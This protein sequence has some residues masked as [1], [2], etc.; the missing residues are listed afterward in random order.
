[1]IDLDD[2]E[3]SVF[4]CDCFMFMSYI[5]DQSIDL[6]LTD[7]PFNMTGLEYDCPINLEQMWK[8]FNRIIKPNGCMCIN[9]SQPFTT[10]LNYPNLKYFRYEWIWKKH[11]PSNFPLASSQPLKY[12]ENISVFCQNSH[13]YY[14]QM[15]PRV[16]QRVAQGIKNHHNVKITKQNRIFSGVK[17][18]SGNIPFTKYDPNEK[19]P[20]SIL[21]IPAVVST[22]YEKEDHPF[23]KPIKLY[24][25]LIKTYTDPHM[26]IF[27]PFCGSG[28]SIITSINTQRRFIA[29]ELDN[30]F[31]TLIKNRIHTVYNHTYRIQKT[32]FHNLTQYR[33]QKPFD[34][35]IKT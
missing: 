31:I 18:Q 13:L 2:I 1:M 33:I 11:K 8:E 7:P 19:F 30:S 4:Q 35:W 26:V 5:P 21:E 27:D 16:N 3:N 20:S 28:T 22:S 12:H 25:L 34:H 24:E 14:P 29:C 23:Q 17:G 10:L 15:I 9:A 6:I 32:P